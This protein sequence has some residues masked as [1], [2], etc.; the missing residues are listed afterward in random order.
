MEAGACAVMLL[1]DGLTGV[2]VTGYFDGKI[3]YMDIR[4]AIQQRYVELAQVN[5]YEQLGFCFGRV[6]EEF[7]PVCLKLEGY[8]ERIY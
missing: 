1:L 5:L 6:R 2:T 4:S 7:D 3:H 8:V